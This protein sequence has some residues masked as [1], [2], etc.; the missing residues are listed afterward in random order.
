MGHLMSLGIDIYG[1][2]TFTTPS[3]TD[4]AAKMTRFVDGLQ[5]L[6]PNLPLRV[7]P[8]RIEVFTP[9]RSR[10]RRRHEG[11]LQSQQAAIEAWNVELH[12][13]LTRPERAANII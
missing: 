2:A 13:R 9:V 1:Y 11:P 7:A 4:L 3:T 8:L 12:K 5:G 10:M 6:H